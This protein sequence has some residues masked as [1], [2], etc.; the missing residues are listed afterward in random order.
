MS[1]FEDISSELGGNLGTLGRYYMFLFDSSL[2]FKK[3][4]NFGFQLK[5]CNF[6]DEQNKNVLNTVGKFNRYSSILPCLQN[7]KNVLKMFLETPLTTTCKQEKI[8]Q[9]KSSG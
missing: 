3:H 1:E 6:I 4:M 8:S 7:N 2:F 9:E 5:K